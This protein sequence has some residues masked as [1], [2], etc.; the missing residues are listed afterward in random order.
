MSAAQGR[1]IDDAEE[2]VAPE[3][4]E[5]Y[6]H[7]WGVATSHYEN[8]SVGSWLL[9]RR[10][11][12]H[13]AAIYAFARAADDIADEGTLAPDD[14]VAALDAWD[15][16]LQEAFAG[17]ASGPVFVAVADTAR[18]F[19][20]PID[21]FGMLLEA[22]RRDAR[23]DGFENFAAL[24][25]YCRHSADPVGH[26]I[27]ALFGYRD[28][29]RRELSDCIC[30]GLQLANFC[31]DVAVDAAKG[32]LYVPRDE[33]A[34]FGCTAE[35]VARGE[36]TASVRRLLRFQ[37]GRARKL[38]REG[39]LLAELVEPRLRREVLLFA[40]G[41]LAIL[42]AVEAADFDVFTCRPEVS[43][44]AKARLVLRALVSAAAGRLAAP[45]WG[46]HACG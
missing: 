25:E 35:Q 6:R 13:I 29:E 3:V 34:C 20:L 37:A 26:L 44:A 7:C 4:E 16:K 42:R 31:Q 18:R 9:P 40:W 38:L 24:R 41:G 46:V 19:D 1:P 2:P 36:L 33:L 17:R 22:F 10:L 30:T 28:D 43:G 15:E 21:P 27:L 12:R 5:A 8:F 39:L 45:G 23:F 11:R 32:R 14:R